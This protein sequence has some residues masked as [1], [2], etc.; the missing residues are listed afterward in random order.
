MQLSWG[1]QMKLI[2]CTMAYGQREWAKYLEVSNR[3]VS[4]WETG[5]SLPTAK[6]HAE[7]IKKLG[8]IEVSEKV[9]ETLRT[10]FAAEKLN[11]SP[12]DFIV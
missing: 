1:E 11:M 8:K 7:I 10:S 6:K 5:T 2:R 4:A 12:C 9:I 3:T